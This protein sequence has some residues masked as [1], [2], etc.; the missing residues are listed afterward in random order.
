M[1]ISGSVA[2]CLCRPAACA[3]RRQ[4]VGDSML[5][6]SSHGPSGDTRV[7]IVPAAVAKSARRRWRYK[8]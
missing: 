1:E 3:S 4:R 7:D 8:K 6:R 5:P 2:F